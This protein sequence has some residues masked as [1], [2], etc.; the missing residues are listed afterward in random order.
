MGRV[1][2]LGMRICA[3]LLHLGLLNPACFLLSYQ[4]ISNNNCEMLQK[5]GKF[6]GLF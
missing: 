5:E 1:K 2:A 4:Y 3:Q 6:H